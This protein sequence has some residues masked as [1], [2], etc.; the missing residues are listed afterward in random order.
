MR[1]R[2]SSAHFSEKIMSDPSHPHS[3]VMKYMNVARAVRDGWA[4]K[5]V[6]LLISQYM[7]KINLPDYRYSL[8]VA[9]LCS[10]P[11]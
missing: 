7:T 2:F 11:K 9:L 5:S 8:D 10:H 1:E 3:L 4:L 6:R